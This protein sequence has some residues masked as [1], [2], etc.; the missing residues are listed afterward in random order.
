MIRPHA[1]T[2][3]R[4]V[5]VEDDARSEN[6]FQVLRVA[7]E[8]YLEACKRLRKQQ[9]PTPAGQKSPSKS[10]PK[11]GSTKKR[12]KDAPEKGTPKKKK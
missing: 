4:F 12:Q 2:A 1:Y 11:K 5:A 10:S 9:T 8:R 6:Q 3:E 7:M